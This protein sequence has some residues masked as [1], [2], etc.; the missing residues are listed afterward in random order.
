MKSTR[1]PTLQKFGS[2]EEAGRDLASKL[3]KFSSVRDVIVLALPKGGVQVGAAVAAMLKH[4]FD[5]LLVRKITAPGCAD[6]TLGA[7]TRGGVRTLNCAMIDRLNLTESEISAAILK[8]SLALARSEK[9]FRG[10]HPALEVAD[11]TV[12]LVDDGTSSCAML[13]D[14]I[15]LLRRLHA[16]Q[17]VVA[18]PALNH[19]AACDLR[20]EADE[21]VILAEPQ[22]HVPTPRW[23]KC[24]PRTTD[25]EVR[26]LLS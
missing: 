10:D 24:F 25:A 8:E 4:P 22:Y 1:T 19:S 18:L 20:L 12:I 9:R 14:A 23:Y 3:Q 7:I 5:I 21:V 2:R 17:V 16:D 26:G 6:A 11:Q 15:H 13:R